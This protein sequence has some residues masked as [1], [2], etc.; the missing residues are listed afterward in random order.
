MADERA[1][2]LIKEILE[3]TKA[4]KLN[5]QA[6]AEK[7][8]YI[9]PMGGR[10]TIKVAGV[11]G[12]AVALSLSEDNTTLLI[13]VSPVMENENELLELYTLVENQVL[14]IDEKNKSID[15]AISVLKNL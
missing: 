8:T 11:G 6:T 13:C 2:S 7:G 4:R 9:A 1:E 15:Q 5:W 12:N 3:K 14:K 10:Y